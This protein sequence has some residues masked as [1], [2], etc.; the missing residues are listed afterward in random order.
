M[1]ALALLDQLDAVPVRREDRTVGAEPT[2]SGRDEGQGQRQGQGALPFFAYRTAVNAR[3]YATSMLSF[4]EDQFGSGPAAP[5]PAH[6]RAVN[7]LLAQ[8]ARGQEREERRLAAVAG[9]LSSRGDEGLARLLTLKE[10]C[11]ALAGETEKVWEF[12]VNLFGQRRGRLASWLGAIDR[13]ALDCYQAVWLGLGVARPI[14]SPAPFAYSETGF[15]PATFRRGVRL[16]VLGRQANPF[17]LVKV[18]RHRLINPWSLGAVPHEVAHNIQA[19]LGLWEVL[20]ERIGAGFAAAGLEERQGA[21]WRRWHK[22]TYADLAGTLL[23]GPAYVGSLMDVVGR[24]RE[25]TA[26]W[27]DEAVHPTPVIR[28]P[29]NIRLL[30]RIGFEDDAAAFRRA[31]DA[32]YPPSV[33]AAV[34]AWVRAELP[35][36]I[37]AVLDTVVFSRCAEYGGRSLAE[38]VCFEPKHAALVR[39]AATR[40]ELGDSTGVLPERFLIAAARVALGRARTAPETIHRAFYAALARC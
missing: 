26:C 33:W 27:D 16:G 34:P 19:D 20:P 5:G 14:P 7:A 2:S 35:R 32:L 12:Y 13:I 40:L 11:H 30:E 9:D 8:L 21:V 25:Q 29:L 1:N 38:V 23:I 15:G 4:A 17:P 31:W 3:R 18:P 37:D 22:E 28:V 6:V 36:Q 39:E 10:R 24:S